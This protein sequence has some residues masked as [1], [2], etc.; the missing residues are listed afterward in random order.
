MDTVDTHYK[1]MAIEPLEVMR[2]MLSHEEYL[3]FLK[4]NI[5]KYSMRQGVKAGEPA[6]KDATKCKSCIKLLQEALN[7]VK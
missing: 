3:G 2:G 1:S 5:I 6:S 4:G 7:N